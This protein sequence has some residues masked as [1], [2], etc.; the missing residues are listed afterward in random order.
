MTHKAINLPVLYGCNTW[1]LKPREE[2]GL[3][4]FVNRVLRR[5]FGYKRKWQEAGEHCVMRSFISCT[6]HQILLG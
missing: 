1:S 6:L 4:V 2:H 5:I 3:R